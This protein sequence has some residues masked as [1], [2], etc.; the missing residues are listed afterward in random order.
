MK[1]DKLEQEYLQ[2]QRD[3][4]TLEKTIADMN[5][6]LARLENRI[7]VDVSTISKMESSNDALK[8]RYEDEDRRIDVHKVKLAQLEQEH[9]SFDVKKK[10]Q[11]ATL[12]EHR[13][14]LKKIHDDVERMKR[15]WDSK[16]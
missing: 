3:I 10:E 9:D 16:K 13:L 5:R 7:R 12:N 8:R 4:Q 14:G 1:N 2:K 11:V 15:E 6:D